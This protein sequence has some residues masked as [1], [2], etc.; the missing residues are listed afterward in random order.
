MTGFSLIDHS[1]SYQFQQH[2]FSY[3]TNSESNPSRQTTL[4][5]LLFYGRT[6]FNYRKTSQSKT[7]AHI[8]GIKLF[9]K[10]I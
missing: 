4:Y 8:A 3:C 6:L 9:D 1:I 2:M 10:T 5:C 7:L